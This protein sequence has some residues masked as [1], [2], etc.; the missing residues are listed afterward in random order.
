MRPVRGFFPLMLA[1]LLLMTPGCA[2]VLGAGEDTVRGIRSIE[3]LDRAAVF[4][5]AIMSDNKGDSPASDM[6]FARMADWIRESGDRFVIGL[7][8]HVKKG[9]GNSFIPFIRENE[10]WREHFYPNAADG[11]NEYYGKGQGDWG[12]GGGIFRD[13]GLSDRGNV[14]IRDNGCEYYA[15]IQAEGYTVHLIQ[16]HFPDQP[17][18]SGIAFPKDSRKW[19]VSTL[20]SIEKGPK[21]IIVACA[22]SRYGFWIHTLSKKQRKTVMEKC[23][24][25]LSATTHF[26]ERKI[27]HGY[28]YDGAL[29][30]NT[31]SIT[32]PR[33]CP[34]GYIQVHVLENPQRLVAQYI[35]AGRETR[36]L[37]K[38]GGFAF[39]KAAGGPVAA[40]KFRK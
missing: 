22:H 17:S 6:H 23:D 10:W 9:W 38:I 37:S 5:F 33:N 7:G 21:D 1:A 12:A 26:W 2:G 11:E 20:D 13:A 14:T 29:V 15:R 8:D 16:L 19:L 36:E 28:E 24:L 31:G 34:Y 27:V 25:V 32:Y 3:D 35:D 4:T 30:L 18:K 40:A 39:I